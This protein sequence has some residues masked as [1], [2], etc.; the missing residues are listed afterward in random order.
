M[1][2]Q[3]QRAYTFIQRQNIAEPVAEFCFVPFWKLFLVKLHYMQQWE[4][5]VL[6]SLA[7]LQ[8]TTHRAKLMCCGPFYFVLNALFQGW[9]MECK[10][11]SRLSTVVYNLCV[12]V[13]VIPAKNLSHRKGIAP[14]LLTFPG[15][16]GSDIVSPRSLLYHSGNKRETS[17]IWYFWNIC[18]FPRK[19][20]LEYCITKLYHRY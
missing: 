15:W 1:R 7:I 9:R 4:V 17:Y 6:F 14:I 2:K 12:Y 3:I 10:A 11:G 16:R 20:R 5:R 8:H 13:C 19:P 18:W